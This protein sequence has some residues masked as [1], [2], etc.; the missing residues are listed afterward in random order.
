MKTIA[1]IA[2]EIG[3]SK[4]AIRNQIAKLGLQSSLRKNANHFAIDEHQ[5]TLLKQAFNKKSQSE[6]ANQTQ[7][8]SETTLRFTLRLLEQEIVFLKEQIAVKDGQIASANEALKAEQFLHANTK[9]IPLLPNS[10]ESKKNISEPMGFS[11]RLKFLF[12]GK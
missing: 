8:E 9:N 7:S 5:E 2:T 3:V 4:Q 12:S 11:K 10:E 1:Q 6:N